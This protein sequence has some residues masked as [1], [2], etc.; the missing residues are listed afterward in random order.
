MSSSLKRPGFKRSS[1]IQKQ[2]IDAQHPISK[3]LIEKEMSD[4]PKISQLRVEFESKSKKAIERKKIIKPVSII[5]AHTETYGDIIPK[6]VWHLIV[7]HFDGPAYGRMSRVNKTFNRICNLGF[8]NIYQKYERYATKKIL[9]LENGCEDVLEY[10]IWT[11]PNRDIWKQQ[12]YKMSN[13]LYTGDKK[14]IMQLKKP[15]LVEEFEHVQKDDIHLD[16]KIWSRIKYCKK[17]EKTTMYHE[18]PTP[19]EDKYFIHTFEYFSSNE[20]SFDDI[21][22]LKHVH[23]DMTKVS[24]DELCKLT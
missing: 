20:I 12:V 18:I 8:S 17:Y 22:K 1:K 7:K 23:V 5:L 21:R 3:E 2:K 24:H 6:D 9:V 15:K 16:T 11:L 10:H 14:I 13:I 19:K 4:I